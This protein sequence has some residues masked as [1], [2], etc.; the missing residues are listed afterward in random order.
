LD[1]NDTSA[2]RARSQTV[3]FPTAFLLVD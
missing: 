3:A 1:R 2:P